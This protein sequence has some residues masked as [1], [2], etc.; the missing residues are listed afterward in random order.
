MLLTCYLI[1]AYHPAALSMNAENSSLFD[2]YTAIDRKSQL[3]RLA[4][5]E[6]DLIVI[7]GGIT[8]AGVAREAALRGLTVALLEQSD[9]A[10]GT[11]GGSSKLGH[12][13]IRY[14]K[15]LDFRLVR[16]ATTE[17]NWLRDEGLP[18]LVRPLQFIYPVF[19]KRDAEGNQVPRSKERFRTVRLA[20]FL[21]DFLCGFHNYASREV[22]KDP[23]HLKE[24]EPAFSVE[25]LSG[26]VLYYDTNLDDARLTLETA[27]ESLRTGKACAINYV[28]VIDLMRDAS[29]NVNGVIAVDRADEV[30]QNQIR[31]KA[32]AVVNATG[33]WADQILTLGE[34]PEKKLV[35]PTKGVHLAVQ[36]SDL[37]VN[38]AFGIRSIDDRRFFFVL[39]R[40]NWVLIG[41]TDTDFSGDP[42]DCYCSEE[43]AD[44]LR[45]TVKILFPEAKIEND[46][47][48]GSYASLRPL[49]FDP[50]KS[51][52]S[53]S[54][55]HLIF[56][57]S[58]GLLTI[59][60]GKLTTFRKMAED[61]LLNH[62]RHRI[63]KG[64]PKFPTRK[65]LSKT[66]YWVAMT[67][68]D[69]DDSEE[70]AAS[71]LDP[72]V[73]HHLFEQYG[74]GGLQILQNIKTNPQMANRLLDECPATVC[75]WILGEIEYIVK[76]ECPVHLDDVLFR[77]MEIA[78]LARPENQ[79]KIARSVAEYM[80]TILDW[81]KERIEAEIHRYLDLVKL[82]SF[83]YKGEIPIPEPH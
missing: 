50:A 7:G 34:N 20:V 15:Q 81:S 26:A 1:A 12:G 68:E 79:G 46:H 13:G 18:H 5:T 37:P 3:D 76:R 8:G 61:L 74:K 71:K 78:W 36:R 39:P 43:D 60:G 32:K 49:V 59:I 73:L 17:R 4:R 9:F 55:K 72:A 58:D 24:L 30:D 57:S 69:W 83:F 21:Y 31:V 14:L 53:L 80:G 6:W 51:E 65:G 63:K 66:A 47:L 38:R 62:I 27:W 28:Q 70:V 16:E 29:G 75:P 48:L 44:Y 23:E 40:N 10:F 82:N 22:I 54:R 35:R 52:S 45:K 25:G 19:Q 64:F 56:Q 42:T 11:S 67:R 41:T 33:V 77:R 2:Q